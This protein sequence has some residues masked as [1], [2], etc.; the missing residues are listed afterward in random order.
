[1][2][3]IWIETLRDEGA[4]TMVLRVAGQLVGPWVDVLEQECERVLAAGSLPTLEVSG[5]T[6]VSSAGARLLADLHRRGL[7]LQGLT[8]LL[9][10]MLE[11]C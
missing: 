2:A 3:R 1:M 6:Y 7:R 4:T 10:D 8:P 11:D 9:T 5:L